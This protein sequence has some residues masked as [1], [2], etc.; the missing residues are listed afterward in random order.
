M[1]PLAAIAIPGHMRAVFFEERRCENSNAVDATLEW[2]A[3]CNS[4]PII[5]QVGRFR[6]VRIMHWQFVHAAAVCREGIDCG[7]FV[8]FLI[9]K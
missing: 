1:L 7:K 6:A 9:E 5:R 2:D 8:R 3:P 4:G